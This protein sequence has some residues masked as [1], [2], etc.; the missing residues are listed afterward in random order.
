M[1]GRRLE[2]S[3]GISYMCWRWRKNTVENMTRMTLGH[4]Q[5]DKTCT[6]SLKIVPQEGSDC[7]IKL[8]VHALL[9]LLVRVLPC[10]A[11]VSRSSGASPDCTRAF[12]ISFWKCSS[13]RRCSAKVSKV[14]TW[15]QP[16]Q[17]LSDAN[18]LTSFRWHTYGVNHVTQASHTPG[19]MFPINL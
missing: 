15:P 17:R 4:C 5:N 13:L 9:P 12:C 18:E 7:E 14:T 10:V 6:F 16:S 1:R 19:W 8:V 3:Y 11:P 2:S